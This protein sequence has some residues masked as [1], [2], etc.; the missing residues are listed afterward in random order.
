MFK[1]LFNDATT[2]LFGQLSLVI[3]AVVF[4]AILIRTL[5]RPKQSMDRY[6]HLPFDD[7]PRTPRTPRNP[8]NPD[9]GDA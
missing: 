5:L 8:R 4:A 9:P 2:G 3:F 1:Q 7:D 6:A